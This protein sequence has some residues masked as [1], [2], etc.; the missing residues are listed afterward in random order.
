MQNVL[1]LLCIKIGKYHYF[2]QIYKAVSAIQGTGNKHIN[3]YTTA[4]I[5][6]KG[7]IERISSLYRG[8]QAAKYISLEINLA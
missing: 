1:H 4:I 8:Y 3:I 2:F 7:C 5:I 6:C